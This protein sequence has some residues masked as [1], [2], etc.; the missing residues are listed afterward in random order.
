MCDHLC[1]HPNCSRIAVPVNAYCTKHRKQLELRIRSQMESLDNQPEW[2]AGSLA[3]ALSFFPPDTPIRIFCAFDTEGP[4]SWEQLKVLVS[5]TG[6][7]IKL[8]P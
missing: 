8:T 6:K 2:T 1:A 3:L 7:E 5:Q 4:E